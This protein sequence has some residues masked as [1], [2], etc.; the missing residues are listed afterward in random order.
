M[1]RWDRTTATETRRG[2]KAWNWG[3]SECMSS[4]VIFSDVNVRPRHVRHVTFGVDML[5][6]G[7]FGTGVFGTGM[8][9]TGM[10]GVDMF[11]IEN[12]WEALNICGYLFTLR[13]CRG[14]QRKR[15]GVGKSCVGRGALNICGCL[16]TDVRGCQRKR[17]GVGK[18]C[19]GGEEGSRG[20]GTYAVTCSQLR[21]CRGCQ[22]KRL[23]IGKSCV[24]E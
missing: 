7:I 18:S 17:L 9:G 13:G 5:G 6:I 24:G 10:F 4:V 12:A 22:R 23:G 1:H 15:F 20:L 2:G 8:F 11:G 16:F 14:C 3:F 21:G 19:V